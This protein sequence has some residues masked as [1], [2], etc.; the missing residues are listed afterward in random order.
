M[1]M[2]CLLVILG[3]LRLVMFPIYGGEV[4]FCNFLYTKM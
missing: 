3:G 4:A 1:E 2:L